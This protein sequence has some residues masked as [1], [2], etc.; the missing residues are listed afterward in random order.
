[1]YCKSC[2]EDVS[3]LL[4]K[5]L[6]C[7]FKVSYTFIVPSTTHPETRSRSTAFFAIA[8][9]AFCTLADNCKLEQ[10][11]DCNENSL[12][13][14]ITNKQRKKLMEYTCKLSRKFHIKNYHNVIYHE[15][16][17]GDQFNAGF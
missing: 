11:R 14:K 10:K 1:M 2:T 6:Y 9:A 3:L 5:I 17:R 4:L 16:S 8:V 15:I 12:K 13:Y 7:N